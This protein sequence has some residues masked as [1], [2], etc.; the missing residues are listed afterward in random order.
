MAKFIEFSVYTTHE[1]GDLVSD[2]LWSYTEGGVVINDIEDVIELSKTGKTWDYIDDAVLNRD[3]TVIVSA[4]FPIETTV[5]TFLEV[6]NALS[7]L[8]NE[9]P[10]DLGSLETSK[11]EVDGD[12]WREIWKER[13]KPI[14]IG[15]AVIVPEWIDYKEKDGDY[16]KAGSDYYGFEPG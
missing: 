16:E 12:A 10:F 6:E 4:Y 9:S 13:F 14:P 3:K 15:R 7:N 11:R 5:N 2:L 8:K 1:G